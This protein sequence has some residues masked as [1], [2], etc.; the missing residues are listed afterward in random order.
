[1]YSVSVSSVPHPCS[2]EGRDILRGFWTLSE[3]SD[4]PLTILRGYVLIPFERAA[5]G[6]NFQLLL[7]LFLFWRGSPVNSIP[8]SGWKAM[9]DQKA[10]WLFYFLRA[11]GGTLWLFYFLWGNKKKTFKKGERK[12][13]PF[14]KR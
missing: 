11:I 1:M 8:I 6:K 14:Q 10:P 3:I 5:N 13:W 7:F 2:P 12:E 9:G 4:F